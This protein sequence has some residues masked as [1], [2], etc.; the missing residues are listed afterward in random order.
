MNVLYF[1]KYCSTCEK[2]LLYLESIDR[3]DLFE[4]YVCVDN[5]MNNGFISNIPPSVD[6]V[7]MVIT[8]DYDEPLKDDLINK[9]IDFTI[10][11]GFDIE[12][13]S[14][15]D[16]KN[17]NILSRLKENNKVESKIQPIL[18]LEENNISTQNFQIEKPETN[19]L[20]NLK[21]F[22]D[23]R[24]ETGESSN[25][26]NDQLDIISVA[27]QSH[28]IVRTVPIFS[29]L[30]TSKTPRRSLESRKTPRKTRENRDRVKIRRNRRRRRNNRELDEF[31]LDPEEKVDELRKRREMEIEMFL[32]EQKQKY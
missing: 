2:L 15:L 22:P 9:W 14:D 8:P 24:F 25:G 13:D 29:S 28:S 26:N 32:D 16:I 19:D 27:K 11:G 5:W 31:S 4:K 12:K 30:E 3:L 7:P 10:N 1:S 23:K 18:Q 6:R 17:Q 21:I 20:T